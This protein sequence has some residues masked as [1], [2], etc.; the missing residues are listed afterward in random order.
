M[1]ETPPSLPQSTSKAGS[2][3]LVPPEEQFWQRY[4]PHHEFQLSS[5][6]SFALH[7]LILGLL[8]LLGWLLFHDF[9]EEK[10]PATVD[11]VR[12]PGIIGK[13]FGFGPGGGGG[14]PGGVGA[15]AGGK[16]KTDVKTELNPD[17]VE[18]PLGN[19]PDPTA[20]LKEV[21]P[22]K[23]E[24]NVSPKGERTISGDAVFGKLAQATAQA[25]AEVN[26]ALGRG[27]GGSGS[28]GGKDTGT[29]KGTGPGKDNGPGDKD[30]G[31]GG[32]NTPEETRAKRQMRWTLIFRTQNGKDY[33]DQLIDLGA[34]LAIPTSSGD[35]FVIR[36]LKAGRAGGKVENIRETVGDRIFWTDSQ[37]LSVQS[38]SGA[39]GLNPPPPAIHAF[40]PQSLE[41]KLLKLE[42]DYRGLSE[43]QI[44]ETR[45]RIV[46][47]GGTYE[48]QVS[49]QTRKR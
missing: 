30:K 44:D 20:L 38:L 18:K 33:R 41:Q 36:D 49:L 21:N 31:E 22:R 27:K 10:K 25:E 28:G 3:L 11:A 14:S 4:S 8:I 12:I 7:A 23:L 35:Y 45:F 32:G 17:P 39:L 29:G 15:A 46:R 5:A 1:A 40:F 24:I 47:R 13:K 2:R 48:P 37:P 6:A 9:D 16:D 26:K 43:D 19:T 34:I 42:L